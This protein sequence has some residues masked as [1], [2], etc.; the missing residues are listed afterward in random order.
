MYVKWDYRLYFNIFIITLYGFKDQRL[1][2]L[3]GVKLNL[4]IKKRL[5]L[6]NAK[7]ALGLIDAAI[8]SGRVKGKEK[9][10]L[11][12]QKLIILENLG[13]ATKEIEDERNK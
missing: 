3:N 8:K 4:N 9:E 5:I 6:R 2:G 1:F 7:N 12:Q 11:L 10:Q 13:T